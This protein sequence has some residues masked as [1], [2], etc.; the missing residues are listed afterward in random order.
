MGSKLN[1]NKRKQSPE[2]RN[3][4]KSKKRPSVYDAVAGRI[5]ASGFISNTKSIPNSRDTCSSSHVPLAPEHVLF[6]SKNAPT[7]FAEYDIYFANERNDVSDLP[8][9]DL[10]KAL[11]TYTS[12]FYS[13]TTSNSGI[14]DWK[15]LDGTALIAL[16]ILTEELVKDMIGETG[17]LA[18]TEGQNTSA[19]DMLKAS[20]S[21]SNDQ[22]SRKKQKLERNN[23]Q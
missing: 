15:S 14:S 1:T 2:K 8:E 7:R 11:H 20:N 18:L 4:R 23:F 5:S 17:D 12:D 3:Y 16:G 22:P 21:T 13:K 10:L 19:Q 6:R 9:S